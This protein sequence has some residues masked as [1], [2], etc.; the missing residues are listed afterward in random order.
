MSP[1]LVAH[2]SGLQIAEPYGLYST[3]PYQEMLDGVLIY[4]DLVVN[5]LES[6]QMNKME[7][8]CVE[9]GC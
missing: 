2:D 7:V 6:V 3:T 5:M 9:S 8:S 4:A 1:Y